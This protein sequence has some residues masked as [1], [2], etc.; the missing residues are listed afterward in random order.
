MIGI[1]SAKLWEDT[2][3]ENKRFNKL[4]RK[5][6]VQKKNG[7]ARSNYGVVI[8]TEYLYLAAGSF[9]AGGSGCWKALAQH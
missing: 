1:Y 6:A 7:A 2:R 5:K 3:N 9:I 8:V 4:L